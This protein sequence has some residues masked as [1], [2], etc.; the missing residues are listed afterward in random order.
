MKP[1]EGLKDNGRADITKNEGEKGFFKV[2]SLRNIEK[3]GPYL[4][5]GSIKDLNV[6]VRK[7]AEHQLGKT[8]GDEEVN[9]IVTFLNALTGTVP[10]DLAATPELP[11]N[12]PNTPKGES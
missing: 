12:G 6:M 9:S 8:L 3:T 4:H 11:A 1:W 5:D 7:M 2:P 10:S